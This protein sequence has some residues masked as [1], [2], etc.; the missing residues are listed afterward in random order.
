MAPSVALRRHGT[1]R[2]LTVL[3]AAMAAITTLVLITRDDPKPDP[4]AWPIGTVSDYPIG[5]PVEVVLDHAHVDPFPL[6]AEAAIG[7]PR[8]LPETRVWVVNHGGTRPSVFS[9]RSPWLGCRLVTADAT[10]ARSY[11]HV[12][13]SDFELGL[14]DPCHG[15]LYS[16]DG[17]HLAGPGTSGLRHFPVKVDPDG[18]LMVDLTDLRAG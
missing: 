9:Q 3:L 8:T 14:L 5:T 15:G 2:A 12:V 13:P 10:A 16:L 18:V 7:V 17:R 6:D 4:S 1:R 11:G